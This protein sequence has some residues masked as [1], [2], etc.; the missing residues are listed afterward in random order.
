[1]KQI[2]Q[3]S[4][5]QLALVI[6]VIVAI[7]VGDA[8]TDPRLA[9][10]AFYFAPIAYA[11]WTL[12]R[13]EASI[14]VVVATSVWVLAALMGSEFDVG[15]GVWN[16][17]I[18]LAA[19][20]AVAWAVSLMRAALERER[21]IATELRS[22]LEELRLLRGLLPVCSTCRKIRDESEQWVS[23]EA[24]LSRHAGAR[25]SH[26]YCPTCYKKTLEDAGLDDTDGG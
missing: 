24:Y 18:R 1:V 15:I 5:V 14:T 9:W 7:G 12:G 3:K 21:Q 19:F 8:I 13:L 11:T 4:L 23:L 16:A 17:T 6:G 20:S 10:F 25:F 26:G 22:A 2:T